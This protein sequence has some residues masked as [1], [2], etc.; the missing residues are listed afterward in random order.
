[1]SQVK[2]PETK[3]IAYEL[4]VLKFYKLKSKIKKNVMNIH[5]RT[6]EEKLLCP[7]NNY[8]IGRQS[9]NLI[10]ICVINIFVSYF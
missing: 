3:T 9:K 4:P 8:D 5:T 1:M 10:T 7:E 2:L 6:K